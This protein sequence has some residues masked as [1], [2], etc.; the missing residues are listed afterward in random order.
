MYTTRLISDPSIT[1]AIMDNLAQAPALTRG[2]VNRIMARIKPAMLA[3]LQAVP[4]KP[5]YP[6]NWASEK[7]RRFVLRKLRLENNLPYRRTGATAQAWEVTARFT[8]EGGVIEAFNPLDHAEFVYGPRQQ[9]FHVDTGWPNA[10]VIV[11]TYHERAE[12]DLTE[13]WITLADVRAGVR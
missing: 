7:Q 10:D 13:A 4:G 9:P 1:E 12:R 11:L 6:L 5:S 8:N 3:E 2:F